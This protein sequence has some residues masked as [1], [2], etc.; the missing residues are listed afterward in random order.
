MVACLFVNK[1]N[2]ERTSKKK[3]YK[4][5][6]IKLNLLT[7]MPFISSNITMFYASDK[8]SAPLVISASE[9]VIN[10]CLVLL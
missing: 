8:A 7:K 1:L 5:D 3:N 2:K 4:D 9:L 10:A 6:S